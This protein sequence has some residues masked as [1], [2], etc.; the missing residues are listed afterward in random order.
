MLKWLS[1]I[2]IGHCTSLSPWFIILDKIFLVKIAHRYLTSRWYQVCLWSMPLLIGMHWVKYKQTQVRQ[3]Y[4]HIFFCLIGIRPWPN[5][6]TSGHGHVICMGNL[7]GV[8]SQ[9]NAPEGCTETCKS[10]LFPYKQ[11]MGEMVIMND[12]EWPMLSYYV[13]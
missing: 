13:I 9:E 10:S 8:F 5:L 3:L 12:L 7:G 11:V 6:P 4:V 1:Y 2:L